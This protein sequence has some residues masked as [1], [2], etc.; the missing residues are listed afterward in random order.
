MSY[1]LSI[2]MPE[3]SAKKAESLADEFNTICAK[4]EVEPMFGFGEAFEQM[5]ESMMKKMGVELPIPEEGS[6][7][8]FVS[9]GLNRHHDDVIKEFYS[10][11]ILFCKTNNLTIFNPQEGDFINLSNPSDTPPSW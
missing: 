9:F 11:L 7:R 2:I 10:E 6:E 5:R 3:Y 1:D 4:Y 8:E